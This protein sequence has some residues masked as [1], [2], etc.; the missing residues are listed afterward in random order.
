[1]LGTLLVGLCM[2]INADAN[3]DGNTN[4]DKGSQYNQ[5][6]ESSSADA[7]D[8]PFLSFID[9]N[10]VFHFVCNFLSTHVSRLWCTSVGNRHGKG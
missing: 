4:K 6:P 5:D 9:G 2:P 10:L 7:A 1:M 8:S 3:A